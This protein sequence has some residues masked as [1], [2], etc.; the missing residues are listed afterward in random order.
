LDSLRNA[1]REAFA[2][3]TRESPAEPGKITLG[4]IPDEGVQRINEA[5]RQGGV[6]GDVSG[7][8]HEVDNYAARHVFKEHGAAS[9]EA[10]RGQ[11]AITADDWAM[12]PDVLAAPDR[13]DPLRPRRAGAPAIAVLK[14]VN[15]HLLLIEEQR[16][17]RRVLAVASMRKYRIG[18]DEAP[19]RPDAPEGTPWSSG[20]PE[21]TRSDNVQ[22]ALPGNTNL[23]DRPPV[24]K[25]AAPLPDV[26]PHHVRFV[27]VRPLSGSPPLRPPA[28][29]IGL[30]PLRDGK[31]ALG[32]ALAFG[33]ADADSLARLAG[34][35]AEHGATAVRPTAGRT[36]LLLG[37]AENGA[38]AVADAAERLGFITRPDDPRRRIAACPGAPACASG[39]IP[40]RAMAA[41]LAPAL[42]PQAATNNSSAPARILQ[43]PAGEVVIHLSGCPKGCAHPAP[44]AVTVVGTERGCGIVRGGS[45][46]G[47]PQRFVAP[48]NLFGEIARIAESLREAGHG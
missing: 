27:M 43:P 23:P 36:L 18:K 14:R 28:E 30:H 20:A 12:I 5:L 45:A 8:H 16:T 48:A 31:M 39:L 44:A 17:G 11:V 26:E 24:R 25:V 46:S 47:A 19:G 15:G 2:R 9:T 4:E 32:V 35:A 6:P 10:L 38:A 29:M 34:I 13:V 21:G 1:L 7:Y 3:A 37:V 22:D 41:A 40:A 42:A 33:H